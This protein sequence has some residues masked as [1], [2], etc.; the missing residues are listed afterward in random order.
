MSAPNSSPAA[1][2]PM[3]DHNYDGMNDE[4]QENVPQNGQNHDVPVEV[5]MQELEDAINDHELQELDHVLNN[6]QGVAVHQVADA[7]HQEIADHHNLPVDHHDLEEDIHSDSESDV[8]LPGLQ[9]ANP[10]PLSPYAGHFADI[11]ID[12][13]NEVFR[14]IRDVT[15]FKHKYDDTK[16]GRLAL[17]IKNN[18]FCV[19]LWPLDRREQIYIEIARKQ[20]T[21]E[22]FSSLWF[23]QRLIWAI[24]ACI[25]HENPEPRDLMK[26]MIVVFSLK[27]KWQNEEL[28]KLTNR[29]YDPHRYQ[30][31]PS[32]ERVIRMRPETFAE[33]N[34][35]MPFLRTR[36]M[37]PP[38]VP[39]WMSDFGYESGNG[40][41]DDDSW[42]SNVSSSSTAPT[43]PL[44]GQDV[45]GVVDAPSNPSSLIEAG[46]DA[47]DDYDSFPRLL[48]YLSTPEE[49]DN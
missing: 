12:P 37:R 49:F 21:K 40:T 15:R 46:I 3:L 41:T 10:G 43:E 8:S 18:P 34:W 42:E 4:N 23:R 24:Q 35:Q 30:E 36:D 39:L 19:E 29:F 16:W 7:I 14:F 28:P 2:D 25:H 38:M 27:W 6:Q 22:A 1:P 5:I 45:P 9:L 48:K 31:L 11:G 17:A 33:E 44:P 32:R 13:T 20:R 26:D 47:D